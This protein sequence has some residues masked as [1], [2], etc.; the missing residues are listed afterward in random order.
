MVG[1]DYTSSNTSSGPGS[2]TGSRSEETRE[3]ARETASEVKD[4]AWQQARGQFEQQSGLAAE[5]TEKLAAVMRKMANEFDDQ[6]QPAFSNYANNF[7]R[8]SDSISHR[9]R[10]KNLNALMDDAQNYSRRQP[11]MFVGGA[12]AA[13]FLMARFLRS[14]DS[15]ESD[16]GE[17][18]HRH[19]ETATPASPQGGENA[20][21]KTAHQQV[22]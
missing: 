18:A 20:A 14:S 12:I 16:S 1:S 9:L 17:T 5:Q 7:A 8:Y 13:G 15:N 2:S 11:A 10:E 21:P 19:A 6:N 4:A 3:R 22:K